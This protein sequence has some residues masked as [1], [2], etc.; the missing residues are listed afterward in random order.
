MHTQP[1]KKH[2]HQQNYTEHLKANRYPCIST[3]IQ[4]FMQGPG[5][6]MSNKFHVSADNITQQLDSTC[7]NV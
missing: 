6:L 2:Q 5:Y 4:S 7:S 3:E 1:K